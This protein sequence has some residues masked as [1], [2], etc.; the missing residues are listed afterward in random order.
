MEDMRA[1][2]MSY[3]EKAL[4]KYEKDE[5][6]A[7]ALLE[8]SL[9]KFNSLYQTVD[10][11]FDLSE[12]KVCYA[13]I[14]ELVGITY[15]NER[16]YKLAA[17]LIKDASDAGQTRAMLY[18]ADTY[19]RNR[20]GIPEEPEYLKKMVEKVLEDK[21]ALEKH[22]EEIVKAYML[23]AKI[24][25]DGIG[26]KRSLEEAFTWYRNAAE[27]EDAEAIA[28]VGQCYLYGEGVKKEGK[29][30]FE[31]NE[32]AANTGNCRGIRNLAI[33]YDFGTGTKRNAEKAI[34]WYKEL[35]SK[36]GNDR[37]AMYRISMCL[38]DPDKEY[39]IKPTD[40]MYAEGLEYAKKALEAGEENANYIIGYCY[41]LGKAVKVDYNKAVAY[42]TKAANSANN[43][44]AKA[45]LSKFSKNGIGS[46]VLNK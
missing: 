20:K 2:A 37:F 28:L 38:C 10:K 6:A 15:Y 26:V 22:P 8:A 5:D 36:M 3:G 1:D 39:G 43:T 34:Y 40:E 7:R 4:A 45:K 41:M 30:A 16:A 29:K 13:K 23:L 33:C 9:D 18:Q 44:K 17:P 32:K 24:H 27:M 21:E 31:W 14:E 12:T 35:L 11:D 46:Y 19:L 42:F 25:H